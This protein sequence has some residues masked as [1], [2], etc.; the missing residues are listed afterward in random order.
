[1]T[2]LF[3][4]LPLRG[5]T[6]RNRIGVSPMCQYSSVD[7]FA[8]DWHLV[9]L[10]GFA[11]GGAGLVFT[12]ATAVLPEGRISPQDLGIWSDDHVPMLQQITRFIHAQ[13]AA[14][15]VQ[16]AHAGRKASTMRPW[17]GNGTVLSEAGGWSNVM[18]P[19]PVAFSPTYPQPVAM[20]GEDIRAT[21][22]AFR[23][24][25]QRAVSAGFDV[26]EL[27]AAHG[28][29]IH[30]FLS[31][32]SNLRSDEYGGS[33][34][35]RTRLLLDIT[36]AVRGVIP[37]GTPLFVRISATDYVEGGWNVDE[38]IQL[39]RLLNAEGVDLIDCSSGGLA[40]GVKVTTGPGYQVPF[41]QAI[42]AK[43]GMATATVGMIT[44]AGQAESIVAS[45]EADMVLLA[46][47]MLRQPHWP[48][49]AASQLGAKVTWPPQY[50]R[51][52]PA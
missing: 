8:H 1:M 15:G 7:G 41:A 9:H 52:R 31:P 5:V 29:L 10:G 28:Y 11:V 48:L 22:A 19:S 39:A 30:E 26:I 34:E 44:E 32:L 12:E 43:G 14:S 27:H 36:R 50:E 16:L 4:P 46:R 21:V 25:A 40:T 45:G 24:A 47:E 42:R 6:L 18:A 33:F 23:V 3:D 38:S 37:E 35:N 17:E 2:S 49:L 20:T 51:A 13:G